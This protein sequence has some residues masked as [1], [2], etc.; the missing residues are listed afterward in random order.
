MTYY[1]IS[2]KKSGR[3]FVPMKEC[4]YSVLG[5]EKKADDEAIR[6]AYRQMALR[7]HPDKQTEENREVSTAKFQIISEAYEVLSNKQ[8]RA[9]YD[10]HRDQILRGSDRSGSDADG[11][12]SSKEDIWR[13]FSSSCFGSRCDDSEGGFYK[14]YRKLFEELARLESDD[15]DD[16]E[17][18]E[19]DHYTSFPSFGDSKSEWTDV[20]SFYA[21]WGNFQSGRRFWDFDKWDVREGENRQVRRAMEVENKK[22]RNSARREFSSAVRS[23]VAFVKRRDSRVIDFQAKQAERERV[24]KEESARLAREKEERKRVAREAAREEEEVRWAEAERLKRENGSLSSSGSSS[25]DGEEKI[26]E[27]VACR[28]I[29]K[30][31]NAF[32]NHEES[33]KHKQQISKLRAELMLS[34]EEIEQLPAEPT[35]EEKSKQKK[36]QK[37]NKVIAPEVVFFSDVEKEAAA[38]A[39]VV[40]EKKRNRRRADKAKSV[41]NSFTCKTCQADFPSKSALFRH[42]DDSGH[43]ALLR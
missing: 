36:K 24:S 1:N 16:S 20:Q 41:N 22:A 26:L 12:Y 31:E 39:E 18:D 34:D 3:K 5:V 14:T 21:Q 27:C 15:F 40:V 42:L 13:Y 2:Q 23:L 35:I 7:H 30:S 38:P 6:K 11:T 8:E 25:S 32:A 33:K 19:D 10:D 9:W 28:K 43:H 4:Y 17:V 29:F 37:K